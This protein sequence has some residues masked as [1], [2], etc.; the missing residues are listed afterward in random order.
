[1]KPISEFIPPFFRTPHN[2]DTN[3]VSNE[4]GLKCDDPS[5]AIQ[6]ERDETDINVIVRR[7]GLTGELPQGVRAPTYGDFTGVF[8]FQSATNAIALA[9]ESF[10]ALPAEARAR[11]H[12]KPQEF[13]EFCSNEANKLELEKLGLVLPK[14]EIVKEVVKDAPVASDIEQ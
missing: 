13:V 2:Y 11:F 9:N 4:T 14:A 12:N 6:S 5:L 8:D 7:F 1:M 10:D 3:I